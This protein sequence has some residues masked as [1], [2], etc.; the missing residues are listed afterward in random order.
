MVCYFSGRL[1]DV[2]KGSS[3]RHTQRRSRQQELVR[4]LSILNFPPCRLAG[5]FCFGFFVGREI[6]NKSVSFKENKAKLALSL[7]CLCEFLIRNL[8]VMSM[9]Q[10]RPPVHQLRQG[11]FRRHPADGRQRRGHLRNGS[12]ARVAGG[13]ARPPAR[14]Q[15]P[16]SQRHGHERSDPGGGRPVPTVPAGHHQPHCT[17]QEGGVRPDRQPAKGRLLLHQVSLPYNSSSGHAAV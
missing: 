7:E 4:A 5:M 14:R 1:W 3:E 15:D 12:A 11:R 17:V 16:Q 13:I 10:T 9:F 8:D 6:L 2:T